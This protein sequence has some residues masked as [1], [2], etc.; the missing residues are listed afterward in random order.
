MGSRGE[1]ITPRISSELFYVHNSD[2]HADRSGQAGFPKDYDYCRQQ[3]GESLEEEEE[4][5]EVK[6]REWVKG[7]ET[8]GP[9]KLQQAE[10]SGF[11][12][13]KLRAQEK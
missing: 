3:V 7:R 13:P 1:G 6:A 2:G 12:H 4:L 8:G 5:K 10:V 9:A 11:N